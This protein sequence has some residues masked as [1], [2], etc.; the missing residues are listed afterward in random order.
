MLDG[1]CL[2]KFAIMSEHTKRL[3]CK[4]VQ[5]CKVDPIGAKERASANQISHVHIN[6]KKAC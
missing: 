4:I 1:R 2:N 3:L 6:G 5:D